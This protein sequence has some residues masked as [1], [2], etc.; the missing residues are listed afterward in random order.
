[1]RLD[2]VCCILKTPY[3]SILAEFINA[4]KVSD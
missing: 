1:M 4:L 2:A 3:L